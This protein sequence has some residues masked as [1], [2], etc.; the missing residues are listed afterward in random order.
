M[1][2]A[3]KKNKFGE[4]F[5]TLLKDKKVRIGIT[6]KSFEW[7]FLFYF[8]EHI[9]CESAP[10]HNELFRIA[11]DGSIKL[12]VIVAF[13]NSAKSTI[14]NTAYSLWSILGIQQ[15]KFVILSGQTEENARQGLLNIKSELESNDLLRSDLGPFDEERNQWGSTAL[16]IRKFD[17]KIM[18]R[19]IGQHIR[20]LR[21]R[22]YR[23]DLI[24]LDDVEDT[25]SVK[26]Q[27]GRDKTFEWITSEAIPAGDSNNTR[28]IAIGN[29]L[30][31]DSSLKR[32]QQKIELGD[33][34]G[35]YREF[36]IVDERGNP[37][38][39]GKF[40]TLADIERLRKET[41]SETS[42]SREYLLKIVPAEDQVIKREWIRY[43]ENDEFP[44]FKSDKYSWTKIGIDLAI[45]EKSSADY[46]AMVIGSLFGRYGDSKLYIHPFPVNE[47]LDFPATVA[48][49]KALADTANPDRKSELLVEGVSYQR[50]LAQQL[51]MDWYNAKA[52]DIHGM[53]KR[54]R[55]SLVSQFIKDGK[56]LFP[57]KGA[58]KLIE[59]MIGFGAE[60]HDDLAD[61]FTI[62]GLYLLEY[63]RVTAIAGVSIRPK[64]LD[65]PPPERR[66]GMF[67]AGNRPYADLDD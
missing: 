48:K 18:I 32:L 15:K 46:T 43:Y 8:R 6:T 67:P 35:V 1:A 37:T 34:G 63:T 62:L 66:P 5:E 28:I 3:K 51:R 10:F 14:M 39:P 60:K 65:Q 24:I 53:D 2:N 45:S 55:L 36:P 22:H 30:H 20:G 57:R 38:W 31:E 40:P 61:A 64:W 54:T 29:L 19:S 4:L 13:R 26:T 42:W 59:Q 56:I 47:R 12:A 21:H 7:F 49:A 11:E 23:P 27:E 58:E 33:N 50:A 17:A 9:K 41:I 52:V 16:V 44:S 25:A